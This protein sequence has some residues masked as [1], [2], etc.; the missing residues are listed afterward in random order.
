VA[1]SASRR[2][3]NPDGWPAE[4]GLRDD[5]RFGEDNDIHSS[6]YARNSAN[7]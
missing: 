1:N 5:E 4:S 7:R 3:P 6:W 2:G